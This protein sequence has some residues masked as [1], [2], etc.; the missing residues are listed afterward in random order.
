MRGITQIAAGLAAFLAAG[1]PSASQE[2]GTATRQSRL[3]E[4][5]TY[6]AQPGRLADLHKLFRDHTNG[7]FKKH[8]IQP[9]GY[10]TPASPP[11]SENTLVY[12]LAFPSRDARE[13]AWK[14]FRSDADWRSAYAKAIQNGKIVR[15]IESTLL[16][17]TDYSPL[18]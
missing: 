7:L 1:Y 3:F 5:R 17:A 11:E 10:W 6:T 12:I 9:V 2:S 18:K 16:L 8:G 4:M 14:D 15:K 13:K